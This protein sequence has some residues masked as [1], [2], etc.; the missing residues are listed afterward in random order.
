MAPGSAAGP[1]AAGGPP[2]ADRRPLVLALGDS[3]TAAADW[4]AHLPGVDVVNA[5]VPGDV[6]QGVLRRL[7]AALAGL[8]G[9]RP[10]AVVVLAGTNDLG[11]GGRT[12]AQVVGDLRAL[13]TRVRTELPAAAV[14]LQSVMPRT[15]AFAPTI[16]QVNAGLAALAAERGLVWVDLWPALADARGRLRKGYTRD[17]LHLTERAEEA[18]FAVL[19]GVLRPL[20]DAR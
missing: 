3:I 1:S 14:V 5:G 8:G 19:V 16:G 9:R 4:A 17:G 11:F 2:D 12:P 6:V 15:A 13:C 18:W 10:D 20:L 7:P